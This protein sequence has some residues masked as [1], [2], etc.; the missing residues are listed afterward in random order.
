[1]ARAAHANCQVWLICLD[2][3]SGEVA[4]LWYGLGLRLFD[5]KPP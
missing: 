3:L 4:K 5:G 1:M 2:D